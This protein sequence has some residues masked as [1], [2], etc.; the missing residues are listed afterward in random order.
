M[1]DRDVLTIIVCQGC[2]VDRVIRKSKWDSSPLLFASYLG[3]QEIIIELC[4]NLVILLITIIYYYKLC[5]TRN[6][7]LQTMAIVSAGPAFKIS[8]FEDSKS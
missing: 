4:C 2:T 5:Y 8:K 7:M 6:N 1:S 3:R